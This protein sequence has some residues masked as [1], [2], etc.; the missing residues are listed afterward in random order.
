MIYFQIA[1]K[2]DSTQI[3]FLHLHSSKAVQN[4][5]Y[6]CKNTVAYFD[7]I[8]H[9]YRKGLKFLSYNDNEI[10]PKGNRLRY[11]AL[12]DECRYKKNIWAKSILEYSTD[13]PQ[14]LPIVDIG[15]RDIGDSGQE[16]YLEI[17][18]VC[19]S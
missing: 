3:A 7:A 1:Y 11:E 15:L 4:V 2:A 17:G 18:A 9:T 16:F 10:T 14:R 8:K 19:F 13:K 12:L 5:T 6:H